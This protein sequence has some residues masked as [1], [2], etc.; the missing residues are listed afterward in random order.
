MNQLVSFA[1]FAAKLKIGDTFT[2]VHSTY[3]ISNFCELTGCRYD[4]AKRQAR[5]TRIG[6]HRI[7]LLNQDG[8]KRQISTERITNQN[9]GAHYKLGG[10][11]GSIYINRH[12]LL[13]PDFVVDETTYR[14][15]QARW[16]CRVWA[17]APGRAPA[18][19]IFESHLFIDAPSLVY[20]RSIAEV[21]HK[22]KVRANKTLADELGAALPGFNDNDS[23][24]SFSPQ[25]VEASKSQYV[26]ISAVLRG[27]KSEHKFVAWGPFTSSAAAIRFGHD[28]FR[29]TDKLFLRVRP[30]S[31]FVL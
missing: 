27:N 26:A 11:R 20:G 10:A 29:H 21:E 13:V 16:G 31:E 14:W 25:E 22:L 19:E 7:D 28:N 17:W 6:K 18:S 12:Q 1:D 30:P 8:T 3:P 4:S 5:V 2:I 24:S 23:R 9:Y 15:S